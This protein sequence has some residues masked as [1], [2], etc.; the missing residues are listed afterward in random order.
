[1]EIQRD[2]RGCFGPH[3]HELTLKLL[4]WDIEKVQSLYPLVIRKGDKARVSYV[5]GSSPCGV[6]DEY[7]PPMSATKLSDGRYHV[8]IGS[9]S[10]R[11]L[12]ESDAKKVMI[13]RLPEYLSSK[14]PDVELVD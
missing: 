9:D 2:P 11:A 13:D 5:S 1:M 8:Y 14:W 3:V 6:E 7:W 10:F 4:G 12:D